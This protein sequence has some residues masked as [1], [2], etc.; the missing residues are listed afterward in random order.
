MITGHALALN[1]VIFTDNAKYFVDV[2]NLKVE[3]R[4]LTN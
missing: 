2:P 1:R 4:L 3:N